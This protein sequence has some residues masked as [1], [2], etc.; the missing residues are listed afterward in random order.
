MRHEQG[1]TLIEIMIVIAL[2]AVIASI[3]IPNFREATQTNRL[4][5]TTNALLGGL[6]YARSEAITQRTTITVCPSA[7]GANAC[8]A[9]TDWST[10]VLV[11]RG[12]DVLRVIDTTNNDVIIT[13]TL[14]SLAYQGSGTTQAA[15]LTVSNNTTSRT[16]NV[17]IIGQ[18]CSGNSCP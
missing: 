8:I 9:S 7:L 6:Q 4:V 15:T 12:N 1:F 2:I 11:M 3:G 18:A 10:G 5:A 13:S 17:N 16:I 14:S